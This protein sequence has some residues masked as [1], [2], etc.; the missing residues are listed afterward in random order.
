MWLYPLS[1]ELGRRFA[2]LSQSL[3]DGDDNILIVDAPDG[4]ELSVNGDH[5]QGEM[6]LLDGVPGPPVLP[7]YVGIREIVVLHLDG[8]TVLVTQVLSSQVRGLGLR[9]SRS[10]TTRQ[11]YLGSAVIIHLYEYPRSC[12]IHFS[13]APPKRWSHACCARV[14]PEAYD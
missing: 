4:D 1:R 8:I 7:A 13:V 14:R 10:S 11:T 6:L 5:W 9:P 12:A 2:L 3:V